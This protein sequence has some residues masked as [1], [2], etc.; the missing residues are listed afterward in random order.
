MLPSLCRTSAGP[1][2]L[3]VPSL[4]QK[5][6]G[7]LAAAARP[8]CCD[9]RADPLDPV[10]F[11]YLIPF[12][13][14]IVRRQL[15]DRK[16]LSVI[17]PDHQVGHHLQSTQIQ[18]MI[19]RSARTPQRVR[20]PLASGGLAFVSSSAISALSRATPRKAFDASEPFG[21]AVL[22]SIFRPC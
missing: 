14:D 9:Y 10:F 4:Q 17:V 1:Q 18:S 13:E 5:Q 19:K 16:F 22:G 20:T 21:D 11:A 15:R 2:T 12:E 3:R 7:R 6:R 8:S